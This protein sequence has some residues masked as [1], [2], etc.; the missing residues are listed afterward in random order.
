MRHRPATEK[1]KLDRALEER[2]RLLR[3]YHA[4]QK[5]HREELF[6]QCPEL[7]EFA[8]R[9]RHISDPAHMLSYVENM[10]RGS[11]SI[12]SPEIRTEALSLVNERI[13]SIRLRSGLPPFD[14][15]VFDEPDRVFQACKR[16]LS[17]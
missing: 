8:Q 5:K 17:A 11:F 13:V 2:N 3:D 7:A 9:L 1:G 15:P 4:R 10:A 14:D 6:K 16:E 12:A